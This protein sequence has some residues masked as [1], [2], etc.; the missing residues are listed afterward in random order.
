MTP[1]TIDLI[2]QLAAKFGLTIEYLWP[3][4]VAYTRWLSLASLII[5][6]VWVSVAV[7]LIVTN[8]KG[9]NTNLYLYNHRDD[10][11]YVDYSYHCVWFIVH[12]C[13]IALSAVIILFAVSYMP[14]SVVG[15]VAPEAKAIYDLLAQITAKK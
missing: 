3:L 1:D 15:I 9:F 10:D 12:G 2:K 6:F 11:T 7:F 5:E 8:L 14:G 13:I 4:V